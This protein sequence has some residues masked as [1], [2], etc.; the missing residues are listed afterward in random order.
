MEHV[1]TEPVTGTH[2]KD[3]GHRPGKQFPDLL[4]R[5]NALRAEGFG[6]VRIRAELEGEIPQVPDTLDLRA[7]GALGFHETIDAGDPDELDNIAKVRAT[8]TALMRTPTIEKIVHTAKHTVNAA[9]LMP[10]AW[11]CWPRVTPS[12]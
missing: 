12:I 3:W 11:V 2:L 9:V 7:P 1:T 4:A 6:L 10:S 5:A 8:M